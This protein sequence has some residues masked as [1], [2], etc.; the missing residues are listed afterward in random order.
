MNTY[1]LCYGK[2]RDDLVKDR[3]KVTSR[4][5]VNMLAHYR[6]ALLLTD[7]GDVQPLCDGE[8]LIA[9]HEPGQV[10][11]PSDEPRHGPV[12]NEPSYDTMPGYFAFN[13]IIT[14]DF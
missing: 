9:V 2:Q 7:V 13:S 3:V 6:H 5:V 11:H 12:G 1:L 14:D 10:F 8:S 4:L